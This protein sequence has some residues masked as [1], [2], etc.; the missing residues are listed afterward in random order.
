[1]PRKPLPQGAHKVSRRITLSPD[2][3][4]AIDANPALFQK[5]YSAWVNEMTIALLKKAKK[6]KPAEAGR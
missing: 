4:A 1:M 6:Q 5:S 3:D 2:V